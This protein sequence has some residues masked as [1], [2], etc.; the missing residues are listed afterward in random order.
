LDDQ[1]YIAIAVAK[2]V[3]VGIFAMAK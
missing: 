2:A 3:N 1:N